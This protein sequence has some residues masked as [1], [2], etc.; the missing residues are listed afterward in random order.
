MGNIKKNIFN[1][2]FQTCFLLLLLLILEVVSYI[3]IHN[4]GSESDKV[5]R[6]FPNFI[7]TKPLAFK[8]TDDYEEVKKSFEKEAV[9]CRG[10]IVYIE[11]NGFPRYEKNNFNC[12][13]EVL[14]DGLRK[15]LNQP[16]VFSK[17]ILIFGGSTVWGTGSADRN[18]IPS[19]IQKKINENLSEKIKVINYG[20]TT[21]TINQQLNLL[22]TVALDSNDLVIFYDG[23]NDIF[24]S[25]VNENSDGSIIGYNQK[26]KLDIYI[27]SVKF[28]LSNNSYTYRLLSL[29]RSNANKS[30]SSHCDESDQKKSKKL[31]EKGFDSYMSN[32]KLA[33]LYV[34][35]RDAKFIHFLQPSLFYKDLKYSEYEIDIINNSPLGV[36]KCKIYQQRVQQGYKYYSDKYKNSPND[37]GLYNLVNSLDSVK[38][39]QEYYLDN[40]HIS[41][42]GNIIVADRIFEAIITEYDKN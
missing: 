31:M 22:R 30:S 10:K 35:S 34:Q 15:T 29:I 36:N 42:A 18:S 27:Q 12:P 6:T 13:G 9:K 4:I 40:L 25:M 8:N 32:I 39:E 3:T 11:K 1:I 28:F 14:V 23:G 17:K 41:S 26:N 5:Y 19:L 38:N 24:Q 21:V 2:I 20:F 16:E 7:A 37:D 33:R